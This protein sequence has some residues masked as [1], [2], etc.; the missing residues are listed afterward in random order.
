MSFVFFLVFELSKFSQGTWNNTFFF[1]LGPHLQ[2]ME[3][4]RLGAELKLQPLAYATATATL[5]LSHTC[6]LHHSSKQRRILNPLNKARD[7]TQIFMDA[8]QVCKA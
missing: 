3:V 5:D 2:Y 4:P 1:F 8:S 7:W 6:D